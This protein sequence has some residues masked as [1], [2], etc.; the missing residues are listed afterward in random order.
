MLNSILDSPYRLH[1]SPSE[2]HWSP[3]RVP[4]LI[5]WI[6]FHGSPYRFVAPL[7]DSPYRFHGSPY[8]LDGFPYRFPWSISGI[9][10]SI[11]W[12]PTQL[13][14]P[15]IDSLHRF[16]GY[17]MGPHIAFMDSLIDFIDPPYRFPLCISCFPLIHF[18]KIT[19][20]KCWL[21]AKPFHWK[22]INPY[23][24]EVHFHSVPLSEIHG[25]PWSLRIPGNPWTSMK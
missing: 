1:G 9:S 19:Y 3:S 12:I 21:E 2:F 16:D 20:L 4:W 24:S 6:L 14:D 8:R 7:I 11:T 22:S 5:S 10:S 23:I 25:H 18:L 13:M 15:L 17:S